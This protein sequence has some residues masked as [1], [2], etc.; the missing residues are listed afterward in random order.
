M[1]KGEGLSVTAASFDSAGRISPDPAAFSTAPSSASISVPV[2][3]LPS[4]QPVS[5]LAATIA[6]RG[7][8][9]IELRK[10][11]PPKEATS[12]ASAI[13]RRGVRPTADPGDLTSALDWD[14]LFSPTG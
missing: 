4:S 9:L 11:D 3:P 10:G 6:G 1:V 2:A 13:S 7:P 14:K 8:H 12:E 5:N